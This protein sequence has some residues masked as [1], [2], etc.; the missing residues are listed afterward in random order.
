MKSPGIDLGTKLE[1]VGSPVWGTECAKMLVIL[2]VALSLALVALGSSDLLT[3]F[4]FKP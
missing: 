1:D 3:C 4:I 2:C